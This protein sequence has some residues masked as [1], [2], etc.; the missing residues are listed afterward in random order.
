MNKV[1]ILSASDRFGLFTTAAAQRGDMAAGM[2]NWLYS[3][4]INSPSWETGRQPFCGWI[5][6]TTSVSSL[7]FVRLPCQT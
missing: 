7:L 1:A 5:E 6:V 4:S 3:P 2:H